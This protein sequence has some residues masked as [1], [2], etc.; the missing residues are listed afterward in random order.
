MY[1]FL[2]NESPCGISISSSV[3]HQVSDVHVSKQ[4]NVCFCRT[5][6][7]TK[8]YN[9]DSNIN[10]TLYHTYNELTTIL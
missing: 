7:H 3:T 6:M 2:S 10:N 9:H 4:L 1:M 8:L 5:L